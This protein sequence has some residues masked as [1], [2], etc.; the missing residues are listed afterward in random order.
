MWPRKK[1]CVWMDDEKMAELHVIH[2]KALLLL[3]GSNSSAC[4]EKFV[5]TADPATVQVVGSLI[6]D[7]I[8]HGG[9]LG[10]EGSA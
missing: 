8:W 1:K 7:G 10:D 2:Q 5:E 6:D 9:G 4:I 3:Q